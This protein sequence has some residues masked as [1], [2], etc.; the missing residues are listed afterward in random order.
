MVV[1]ITECD[2]MPLTIFDYFV[3]THSSFQLEIDKW[4]HKEQKLLFVKPDLFNKQK[5]V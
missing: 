2:K 3:Y 1:R 4:Y 5:T